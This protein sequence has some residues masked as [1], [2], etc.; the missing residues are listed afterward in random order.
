MTTIYR[1]DFT[2]VWLQRGCWDPVEFL[3]C[4]DMTDFTLTPRGDLS[5]SR[6]RVGPGQFRIE[7]VRRNTADF[8]GATFSFY[9]GIVDLLN[10]TPC[11]YNIFVLYKICGDADD[12]FT[13]YDF[14]DVL[15]D[16]HPGTATQAA[17]SV[18]IGPD[19]A[20]DLGADIT[21]E[22]PVQFQS[23]YTLKPLL[24][25]SITISALSTHDIVGVTICDK[26][27]ICGD[28]CGDAT[29]GCQEIWVISNG[30][31]GS[32]ADVSEIYRSTDGGSTWTQITNNMTDNTDDLSDIECS[33]DVIIVSNGTTSEYLYA[34]DGTTTLNLI[35]TPTQI[36]NDVFILGPTKIWMAA[37]G[38]YVYFSDTRGA[39]VETQDAGVATSENLN[40]ISF[41]DSL[42]G[43]AV[44]ANNAFI[45]TED[46][47]TNWTAGTGPSVGVALN[48]VVAVPD[49]NTLFV[50]DASGNVFR[51]EDNG[52]TWVTA[53]A[54]TTNVAG[55]IADI[56]LCACNVPVI[57]GNNAGDAAGV[58]IK[59]N[60]GGNTWE[61]P[62]IP[63]NTGLAAIEC[64]NV[65]EYWIVGDVG[66]VFKLAGQS[67]KDTAS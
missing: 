41:A 35:T 30:V 32:A 49:T 64:C 53:R 27:P 3:G 38:G 52:T 60:D 56:A 66:E 67:Y 15:Q 40:S 47:G 21:V 51:S 58:V 17:V 33:G 37:Q 62:S 7:S 5:A 26:S 55:G 20:T 14:I 54:T 12:D 13:N 24:D 43:Y 45:L 1:S 57:V 31:P 29:I 10:D 61:T 18:G 34:N 9:R 6:Q 25:T 19:N 28:D 36:I 22:L 39:S 23:N 48:V 11:P 46:G 4:L 2:S 16:V 65:N 42:N 63:S 59:S 50:G 44:G 8:G